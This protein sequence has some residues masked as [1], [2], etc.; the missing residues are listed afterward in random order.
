L[1]KYLIGQVL[2]TS[3]HRFAALQEY[4]PRAKSND[5]ELEVAGQRVPHGSAL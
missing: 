3:H 5:W 4:Y 1:T 2:Q